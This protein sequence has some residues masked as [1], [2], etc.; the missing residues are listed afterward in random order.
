MEGTKYIANIT[1]VCTYIGHE[2]THGTVYSLVR[3]HSIVEPHLTDTHDITDSSESPDHFS[4]DFNTLKTPEL[5]TPR[6]SV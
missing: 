4:L 1:Y 6:Y 3:G 5:R 2:C